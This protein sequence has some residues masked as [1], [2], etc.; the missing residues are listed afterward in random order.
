MLS[1]C[2]TLILRLRK[3]LLYCLSK[4]NKF[5]FILNRT[6]S[7]DSINVFKKHHKISIIINSTDKI[8]YEFYKKKKLVSIMA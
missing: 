1:D 6:G 2:C 5:N 4:F 3:T 8:I 7:M